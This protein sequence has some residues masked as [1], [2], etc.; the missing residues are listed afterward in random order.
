MTSEGIAQAPPGEKMG[1]K[2]VPKKG[3]LHQ[4]VEVGPDMIDI[5]RIEKV[6]A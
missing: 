3:E 6:Y 4:D 1:A 5:D 2:S